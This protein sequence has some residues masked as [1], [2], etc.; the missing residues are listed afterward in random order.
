MKKRSGDKSETWRP[1][2]LTDIRARFDKR[3][4]VSS[5]QVYEE[6]QICLASFT[7]AISMRETI[8]QKAQA[9]LNLL[10]TLVI[11]CKIFEQV[12]KKEIPKPAQVVEEAL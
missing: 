10:F 5:E 11:E 8:T 9:T 1:C 7:D 2:S 4:F 3:E 12:T 6:L